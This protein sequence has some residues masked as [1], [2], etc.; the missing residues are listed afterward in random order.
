[1]GDHGHGTHC[2]GIISA[3]LN[4]SI[5]IAGLA[6]VRVMAE[7]GLDQHGEGYK[8]DLTNAIIHAVDQGADILSNSWGV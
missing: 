5:G 3:T 4:N 1:M 6:Q 8:D 2:V 7:K